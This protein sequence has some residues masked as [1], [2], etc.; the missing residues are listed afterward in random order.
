MLGEP[1]CVL[2]FVFAKIIVLNNASL[3]ASQRALLFSMDA[4]AGEEIF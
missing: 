2:L 1:V 4:E 3:K